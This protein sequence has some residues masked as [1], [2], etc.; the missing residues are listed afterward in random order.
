MSST[1]FPGSPKVLRGALVTIASEGATPH[2]IAFQYNPGTVTRK[3][4]LAPVADAGANAELQRLTGVPT[5]TWN[6]EVELDATDALERN[7]PEARASGIHGGLAALEMLA[8]PQTRAVEA[9]D[10]GVAQGILEV[11]PVEGPTT[12]LIWGKKRVLPVKLTELSI[13]EE[14]FDADLNPIR[15]KVTLGLRVLTTTDLSSTHW[16]YQLYHS[17]HASKERLAAATRSS[18]LAA[19]GVS[20]DGGE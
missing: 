13:T 9:V 2:V 5:E 11:A 1:T 20:L 19:T 4:E 6:L 18:S 14:Q 8:F 12:L 3:F 16:A 15:A 7:E 10:A 17:H